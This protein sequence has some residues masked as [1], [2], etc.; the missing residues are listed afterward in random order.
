MQTKFILTF[1]LN[2]IL[3]H[4]LIASDI[5]PT[6]LRCEYLVNPVID[7]STPRMSWVLTSDARNQVQSAYQIL[8]ASSPELLEEG[9]ADLW[10][11]GKV[12][13]NQT[14]QVVYEGSTLQSGQEC[15]WKVRS[16]DKNGD[17][18]PWSE[19]ANWE[20]G[21]L[22]GADWGAEWIGKDYTDEAEPMTFK[23]KSLILPPSP[24]LRKPIEVKKEIQKA[25][26]YVT[27]L[28]LY[29]FK[30]NGKR[31]GKDYLSPGWTDYDKRVYYS[32]HDVGELLSGGENV[33]QA[34]LSYGWYSGYIGY[35]LLIGNPIVRAFYGQT[36]ALKAALLLTYEDGS[37]E[38]WHTDATWKVA[39]GGT[40]AS[41]ILHGETYDAR[42]EPGTWGD[43]SFDDGDWENASIIEAGT[44]NLQVYPAQPVQVTDT[45]RP[46]SVTDRGNG[47]YIFDLGQNF[48][49]VVS[50]KVKGKQGDKVVLRFGEMLHEDGSL[51]VENLRMARA[52]DTYVLKGDPEGEEWAPKFTYHG[53]QYVEVT[54]YP[55]IPDESSIKGLVLGSNTPRAGH[56]E[57][58]NEMVNQL[59]SNIVWTQRANFVDIPT[60][61][62]Q[63]DERMGWT[64][65]AQIYGG[66]SALNMDVS[67]FFTKWIQD[68]HDAQWEYG[69]YPDYAP[70]PPVRATDTFA[71]GWM[72]AGVINPYEMYR[73]YG[74]IR[75]IEK[76]WD[77]MEHFMD[78]HAKRSNGEYFY[79]EGSFAD[80]NPKGG[81][82]DWLSVGK[83][84]PPDMLATFYFGYVADLMA[85][86]A[87]AIGKTD[88]ASHYAQI[89]QRIK[90][91][92]ASHYMDQSSGRFKTDASKYGDGEG[93]VD[94]HM[95]FSGHTQ[96]AYANA[97]Y[98]GFLSPEQE[99]KAG[100][101]LANLIK[102]NDG[103]LA[104]GFLGVKQLLPALS[105]TGHID[106]AYQLL[107]NTEYPSWGFEIEN[108]ATTIWERWDSYVKDDPE[109]LEALN[110]GMN[111]F[112][113]YAFGSV[114]E[115]MFRN[116]G[117]ITADEPGYRKFTIRPEIPSNSISYVS[118]ENQSIN[119]KIHSSWKREGDQ[120]T[121]N[122][123]V[124]VNTHAV[125][126]VPTS[127]EK[128]IS[129]DGKTPETSGINLGKLQDGYCPV[130]LGSGVYEIKAKIE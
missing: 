108:G 126:Y 112:S 31:V 7:E 91:A 97:I 70:A 84:T 34:E 129:L 16:W 27:A 77:Q 116:M 32:V 119:G 83:K 21:L 123:E 54:G 9:K 14:N 82:G 113:H 55:G 58:D 94:G 114:Y 88:R 23:G 81:Y 90:Q 101:H 111:S 127:D 40:T 63:R 61:C 36:P 80:L 87:E 98:K 124:P 29:E 43:A 100:W 1:I 117:G 103:K 30:I 53:F 66:T 104:T 75:I 10:D 78:F 102:E 72:E 11:S 22:E 122:V 3:I 125:V 64:G 67:A 89:A 35:A 48:A 8:V 120:V 4:N 2:L 12:A 74:D 56:F 69:A 41:D 130:E 105:K 62:P 110:A 109:K 18:G 38:E 93:Y 99:K 85:E 20:M 121:L 79:P 59:Y 37:T 17:V 128:S 46:V 39:K 51:M 6:Y 65:D 42:K 44:R 92:F 60:D 25:R 13:G 73:A 86:M 15:H 68:L 47:I 115:W 24:L 76:G 118:T 71:P 107:L 5:Q 106:I 45:L 49:G 26:L 52:T 50:L 96:T 28:G 95:G 33:L 57:T 19:S